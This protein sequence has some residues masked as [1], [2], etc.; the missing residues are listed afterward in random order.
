MR[1]DLRP[2]RL[3]PQLRGK[4]SLRWFGLALALVF[5]ALTGYN[6]ARFYSTHDGFHGWNLLTS[7]A[8]VMLSFF[9]VV[10]LILFALLPVGDEYVEIGAEGIRF[11]S[12]R[13]VAGLPWGDQ[14]FALA[15]WKVPAGVRRGISVPACIAVKGRG[16]RGFHYVTPEAAGAILTAAQTHGLELS[17]TG[18]NASAG[19]VISITRK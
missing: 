1:Y 9:V 6:I 18:W 2:L 5:L 10:G 17:E 4:R 19:S 3:L 12:G 14:Q 7:V 16:I 15:V 11:V 13:R 8:I